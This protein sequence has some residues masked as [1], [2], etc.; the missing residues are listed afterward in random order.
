ME[1]FTPAN[2]K[3][4]SGSE[5]WQMRKRVASELENLGE[6]GRDLT[7]DERAI[8]ERAVKN[9]KAIDSARSTGVRKELGEPF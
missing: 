9:L 6:D 8:E 1:T 7:N 3:R 4:K 2:L 5:L